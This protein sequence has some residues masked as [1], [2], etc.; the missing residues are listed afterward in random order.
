MTSHR[1]PGAAVAAASVT[2]VFWAS[3]FVGIRAAAPHFSPGSLALGRLL[4]GSVVL[5]LFLAVRRQGLPPRAAWPGIAVSGVLWFGLYMVSL[6]WGEEL[7]DAGT[8]AMVVNVGPALMALLAGWLLNEGFPP[9]L[10]A[11][12]AVS[13]AGTVVV[14][15]SMSGGGRA[16]VLGVLLCLVAAITY[17]SGVVAQKPALRHASALQATTFGCL[18]GAVACLPFAGRLVSDVADA[19][20]SATLNV[21]YLGVFPTA[22]A[23]TTWAYALARTTAGKMGST[24]YAV[25][26]VV[27]LLS[28]LILDEVP[29]LLALAGGALCLA[30][31][32]VSRSRPRKPAQRPLTRSHQ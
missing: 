28:W 21:I 4:S 31:V 23:F 29:G 5:L 13:F 2:V 12:I 7:V 16:S 17:A 14:G 3:A 32:A 8:A 19:P 30:G 25:P 20:L 18:I 24:T 26:V 11:G 9:R 27:I 22:V 15:L 10:L 6:N 1:V